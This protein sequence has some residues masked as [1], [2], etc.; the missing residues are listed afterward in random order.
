MD[1]GVNV[2]VVP[3]WEPTAGFIRAMVK[4]QAILI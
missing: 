4:G 2:N 1:L 3:G